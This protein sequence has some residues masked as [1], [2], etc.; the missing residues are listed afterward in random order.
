MRKINWEIV[1]KGVPKVQRYC[2]KCGVKSTFTC[3]HLFRINAH[4]KSLDIWLIYRCVRCHTTWNATIYSCVHPDSIDRDLLARFHANDE[5]LATS[6][7][8]D[9][10][11]LKG[12]GAQP[13]CPEYEIV[14]ESFEV[15]EQTQ[16]VIQ[17]QFSMPLKVTEVL[18]KQL[19]LSGRK[20]AELIARGEVTCDSK[21]DLRRAKVNQGLSLLFCPI[22][23]EAHEISGLENG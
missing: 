6:W 17:S 16:L 20:L 11:F 10:G 23:K 1:Y 15:G 5:A 4:K 2:K 14:G 8:M 3:S 19:G 12:N 22:E 13:L 7:A 21:R 18:K 9:V